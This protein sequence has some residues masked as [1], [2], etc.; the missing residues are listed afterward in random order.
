MIAA[1][2]PFCIA[3]VKKVAVTISRSG[4]PKEMFDTPRIVFP[5]FTCFTYLT[6]SN[7]ASAALSSDETAIA[8]GSMIIFFRAIPKSAARL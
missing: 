5:F 2:S 7:V 1:L 3:I 6:V 4:R 8:S